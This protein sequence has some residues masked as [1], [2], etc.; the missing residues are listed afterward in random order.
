MFCWLHHVW[1]LVV[2]S[3]PIQATMRVLVVTKCLSF[4]ATV[5]HKFSITHSASDWTSSAEDVCQWAQLYMSS[6][7]PWGFVTSTVHQIETTMWQSIGRTYDQ[8]MSVS[9][10]I[11]NTI[12]MHQFPVHKITHRYYIYWTPISPLR[13][14]AM[15]VQA[16]CYSCRKYFGHSLEP[17]VWYIHN[18]DQDICDDIF[19]AYPY[20]RLI[21]V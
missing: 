18:I 5:N 2:A 12:N 16:T 7:M 21:T 6:C 13:T 15:A 17:H 20:T 10:H 19:N 11:T 1:L 8:V 4:L 9:S 14:A 3:A